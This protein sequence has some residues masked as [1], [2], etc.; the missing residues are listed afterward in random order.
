MRRLGRQ[1]AGDRITSMVTPQ[2]RGSECRHQKCCGV[3][4]RAHKEEQGRRDNTAGMLGASRQTS[5]LS[6]IMISRRRTTESRLSRISDRWAVWNVRSAGGRSTAV[7]IHMPFADA[8][9]TATFWGNQAEKNLISY[10]LCDIVN[11]CVRMCE[12]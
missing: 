1:G 12:L 4:C 10:N 3:F 9:G 2:E 8:V 6:S 11:C 5:P 7:Y